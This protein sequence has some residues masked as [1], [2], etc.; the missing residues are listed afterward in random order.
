MTTEQRFC[1]FL[2][3]LV[4]LFHSPKSLQS[5]SYHHLW[6]RDSHG[7]RLARNIDNPRVRMAT[8]LGLE[9]Y[10]Y[11][12][13][14]RWLDQDWTSSWWNRRLTFV[15]AVPILLLALYGFALAAY[16]TLRSISAPTTGEIMAV[17]LLA[18]ALGF[19]SV[20]QV[21][22]ATIR[23]LRLLQQSDH[24][25]DLLYSAYSKHRARTL[26]PI[27]N[28]LELLAATPYVRL[29]DYHHQRSPCPSPDS[30]PVFH[31]DIDPP[32]HTSNRR[33]D[34]SEVVVERRESY[35]GSSE[36]PS[37]TESSCTGKDSPSATCVR[38]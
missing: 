9:R 28:S 18:V 7:H 37:V 34:T 14:C 21:S 30:V 3:F 11:P 24:V 8:P 25:R 2:S 36:K 16:I 4:Y 26:A 19:Y 33:T 22:S 5:H 17:T 6:H 20:V 31:G 38:L 29:P 32:Q 23:L 10:E 15:V 12:E 13:V 27:L 1:L 35:R